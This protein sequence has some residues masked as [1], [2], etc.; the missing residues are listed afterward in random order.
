MYSCSDSKIASLVMLSK[1]ELPIISK[2]SVRGLLICRLEIF[3]KST[4]L[5]GLYA[6]HLKNNEK[7]SSVLQSHF[8]QAGVSDE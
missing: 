8:L 6:G 2:S 4:S 1:L 5:I 7:E 3:S